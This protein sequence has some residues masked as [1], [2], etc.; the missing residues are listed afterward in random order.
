M[1]NN[2]ICNIP[3]YSLTGGDVVTVTEKSKKQSRI[4]GALEL[5]KKSPN[6]T[7]VELNEAKLEGLFKCAP[8]RAELSSDINEQLIVELYSK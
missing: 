3:S 8:Q 4:Q 2:K 6:I 7:W 1:V 5:S